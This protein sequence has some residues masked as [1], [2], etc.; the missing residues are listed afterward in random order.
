MGWFPPTLDSGFLEFEFETTDIQNHS[1]FFASKSDFL[2][3][4]S[5][6]KGR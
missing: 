1:Y 6:A 3:G 4:K 5:K 2:A